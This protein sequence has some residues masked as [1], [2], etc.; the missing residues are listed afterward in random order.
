[1]PIMSKPVSEVSNVTLQIIT[2]FYICCKSTYIK[3]NSYSRI[4]DSKVQRVI[5]PRKSPKFVVLIESFTTIY[6]IEILSYRFTYS[7]LIDY[8]T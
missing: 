2:Q 8:S 6:H 4:Y 3:P 7:F 5:F 1:M